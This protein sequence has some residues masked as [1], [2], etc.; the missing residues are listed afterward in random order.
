MAKWNI[1]TDGNNKTKNYE[2]GEAYIPSNETKLLQMVATCLVNEPKF[3]G[4]TGDTINEINKLAK[5]ISDEYILKLAEYT[6]SE[7]YLR[8]VSQ[9]L[10]TLSANMPDTKEYVRKYAPKIIQRADG[11]TE[12]MACQLENWGKPIPNSLKKGLKDTFPKFDEYQF[13]KY[14]RKNQEVTFK[15]VIMLTHPKEP[16]DIID[17][18]LDDDLK[19]PETWETVISEKGNTAEAWEQLIEHEKLPYFASLRN[20]RNLLEA[21]VSDEHLRKTLDYISNE[22]MVER[23]K[24]LPFRYYSAYN[25]LKSVNDTRLSWVYDALEIAIRKSFENIPYMDGTTLIANDTSGS[26][27]SSI[28]RH[29]DLQRYQ[30]ALLLGSSAHKFTD[31]N[32]IGIFGED[33]ETVNLSKH[34]D[35]IL[36]SVDKMEKFVGK[37]GHSTNGWKAIKW[38]RENDKDI[39]RF[40]VFTDMQIWDSTSVY[41]VQNTLRNEFQKYKKEVNPDAKIYMFDLAGYGD[42][43]FPENHTDSVLVSGWSSNTFDFISMNDDGIEE[44]V[45]YIKNNY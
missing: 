9:Y 2:G 39:D 44:Q 33:W 13:A 34:F 18:L 35:G 6:R 37:V 20:L 21:D 36:S 3:Y 11:I 31:K 23:V 41:G 30:L 43:V 8:S 28:S 29:S 38:A 16:S 15:D 10:L 42:L 26:M 22:D 7:L 19:T 12:V 4:E 5:E 1:K 40:L 32:Y 45:E 17:K 25:A 27:H 14:H 24:V